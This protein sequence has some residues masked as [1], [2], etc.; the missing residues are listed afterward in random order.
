MLN[1]NKIDENMRKIISIAT[2]RDYSTNETIERLDN[3]F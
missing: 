2:E 1:I 3:F